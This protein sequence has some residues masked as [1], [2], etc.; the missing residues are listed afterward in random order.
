MYNK[1][2]TTHGRKCRPHIFPLY[3]KTILKTQIMSDDT[4]YNTGRI[5]NS[6]KDDFVVY[7][8]VVSRVLTQVILK[9]R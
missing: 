6:V 1:C 5:G 2:I 4:I 9:L 7:F 8:T 3:I